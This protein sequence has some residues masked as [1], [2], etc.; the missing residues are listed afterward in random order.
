[1]SLAAKITSRSFGLAAASAAALMAAGS[2]AAGQPPSYAVA[3]RIAIP[4]GGFDFASFDP[5]MRR[6]YLSRTDGALALDVDG[7]AVNGH[8]GAA[9]HSHA[10]IA[11]LNGTEVLI[12]DSGSNSAHL[13]DAR[14]GK[15]IADAPTGEKPDGAILEPAT[16]LAAVMNGKSGDVTLIDPA[17]GKAVGSIAVS[18]GLESPV[19]DG[20]GKI[21]V[22]VETSNRIAVLDIKT[23]TLVGYYPL[24]GCDGPTGMVYAP[25]AKVLIAACANK[26]AKVVRAADGQV[27]ATLPIGAGPDEVIYDPKRALAF[28]PCG[29]DGT[30]QVIAVRGPTDVAVVQTVATA[31][32]ARGGAVDPETGKVYLPT[33]QYGPPA[34]PG[35]HPVAQPGTFMFLVVAPNG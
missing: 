21:Y 10:A 8:L 9:Q 30:M 1:M 3:G 19:A 2:A 12:T 35:G 16:G 14:S 20:T 15:L 29:H 27:T 26:V 25:D 28:I 11:V 17:A 6:V 31:P 4:D 33:A 32:G 5:A 24:A 34:T 13:V 7:G 18:P 22:T 23:R